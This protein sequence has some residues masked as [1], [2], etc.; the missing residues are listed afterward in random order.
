MRQADVIV[1][2]KGQPYVCQMTSGNSAICGNCKRGVIW[3]DYSHCKVC[4]AKVLTSSF[5]LRG[6]RHGYE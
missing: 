4:K 6:Y 1:R 5:R 2:H 3:Y